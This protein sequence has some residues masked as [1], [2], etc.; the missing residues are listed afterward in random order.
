MITLVLLQSYC[1]AF[2]P[3]LTLQA[4]QSVH[5]SMN[6]PKKMNL[7]YLIKQS[8]LYCFILDVKCCYNKKGF[9][10]VLNP[11]FSGCEQ[12]R[13]RPAC[14]SAQ[15][16]QRRLIS[17]FVFRLLESIISRVATSEISIF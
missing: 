16:D 15:T 17:A 5:D 2:L 7:F 1:E 12:Q 9:I 4:T 13:R 10:T 8:K 11:V 14:A 3:S 6:R